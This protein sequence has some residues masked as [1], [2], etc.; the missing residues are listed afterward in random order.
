MF[1]HVESDSL[2]KRSALANGDN[3]TLSNVLEARRAVDRHILV[4][5]AET[6]VLGEVLQVIPSHN[7]GSLHLVGDNHGLQNSTSDGN[8]ASKRALLVDVSSLDSTLGSLEAK[9]NALVVAH[10]LESFHISIRQSLSSTIMSPTFLDFC[11]RTRFRPMK[12][13]SCFW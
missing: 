6:S 9:A 3:I 1:D 4:L 5:L 2:S 12:M 13:A 7:K 11:P 8:I 10:S